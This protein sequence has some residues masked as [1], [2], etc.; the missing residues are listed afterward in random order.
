[1]LP[2]PVANI[3]LR[4]ADVVRTIRPYVE[5][6]P[7]TGCGDLVLDPLTPGIGEEAF[8]PEDAPGNEIRE[9]RAVTQ[10]LKTPDGGDGRAG[11]LN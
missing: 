2:L 4:A 5:F 3:I 7:G 6:A 1:M 8:V 9:T 11:C 10:M